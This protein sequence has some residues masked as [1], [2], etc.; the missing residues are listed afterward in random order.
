MDESTGV[1]CCRITS[2]ELP[3][4]G[5]VF[6]GTDPMHRSFVAIRHNCYYHDDG[7]VLEVVSTLFQPNPTAPS[8][9]FPS[10]YYADASMPCVPLPMR[11]YT[12]L[13]A[14]V[15]PPPV[16]WTGRLR[17]DQHHRN[18]GN[19]RDLIGGA[20]VHLRHADGFVIREGVTVWTDV[21]RDEIT[22]RFEAP[23]EA[24]PPLPI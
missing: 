12:Y 5:T 15:E 17:S 1:E 2:D 11:G 8:C 23:C 9:W 20:R 3:G 10:T 21:H 16:C 6:L 24:T 22:A 14:N 4:T 13:S 18:W 7:A 19:V